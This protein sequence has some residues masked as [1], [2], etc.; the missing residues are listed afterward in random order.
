MLV[1]SPEERRLAVQGLMWW[2]NKIIQPGKPTDDVNEIL[3]K[4]M[5]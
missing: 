1:L 3:V 4:L 5:A 2:R